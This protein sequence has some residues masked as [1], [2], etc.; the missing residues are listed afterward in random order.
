MRADM[1][2]DEFAREM[3]NSFDAPVEGAFLHRSAQRAADRRTASPRSARSEHRR[4]FPLGS[5]ACGTCSVIWLV[6]DRWPRVALDR[7]YRGLGQAAQSHYSDLLALKAK[8][9]GFSYR[10]HLAS[11]RRRSARAV[12]WPQPRHE[13]SGAAQRAG[14][15]G[16]AAH[17]TE[18]GI[19]ATGALDSRRELVRRNRLP[20]GTG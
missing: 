14:H 16:P 19:T 7:L 15:H 8:A 2:P 5:R 1:S 20:A 12:H 10:A 4:H 9:G 13:L 11:A 17:S 6:P 3:L 18:D